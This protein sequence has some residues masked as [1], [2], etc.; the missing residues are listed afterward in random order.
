MS[1][2]TTSSQTI[3]PFLHIGTDWLVTDNLA[4]P[5]VTGEKVIVEG[6]IVDG[7]GKGVGDAIVEIWQANSHGRYAHPE[8]T[9]EKPLEPA[10]KGFGRV[11]TN[12]DGRFAFTTIKPGRVPAAGGGMQ[13]PHL[14]VAIFMRGMLKH[15]F[16]RIY[17]PGDSA[18]AEDPVLAIVPAARRDTLVAKPIAG[19]AGELCWDVILQ[20]TGETVFFDC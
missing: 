9:Q 13:A 3:G 15:L 12:D 16:T 4:G 1:L 11:T 2:Q 10:F 19:R 17:F 5:G 8:D 14:N 18:N 6:R 20:G 7:D